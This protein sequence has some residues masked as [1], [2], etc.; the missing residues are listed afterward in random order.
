[1]TKDTKNISRKN[2]IKLRLD[3]EID[4]KAMASFPSAKVSLT[5]WR[6][7]RFGQAML[8]VAALTAAFGLYLSSTDWV[9][10]VMF[11]ALL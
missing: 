2:E 10:R 6:Q 11:L 8:T 7:Y 3:A 1:M 4:G 5:N 9:G